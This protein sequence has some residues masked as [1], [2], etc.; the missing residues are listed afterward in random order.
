MPRPHHSE[1]PPHEE[2][3]NLIDRR[4]DELIREIADIK[5]SLK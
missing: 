5:R 1:T 2:I 4:F 3:M